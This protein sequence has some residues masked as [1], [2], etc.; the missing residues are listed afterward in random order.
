MTERTDLPDFQLEGAYFSMQD[1][2]TI[3]RCFVQ[4]DALDDRGADLNV[5][6]EEVF[7]QVSLLIKDIASRKYDAGVIEGGLVVI[8]SRDLNPHLFKP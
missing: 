4:R 3:V 1:G 2:A 5:E 6:A 8:T 7:E